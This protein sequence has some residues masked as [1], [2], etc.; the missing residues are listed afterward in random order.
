MA[1]DVQVPLMGMLPSAIAALDACRQDADVAKR[2][3]RFLAGLAETAGNQVT[4]GGH[5][6]ESL[7]SMLFCETWRGTCPYDPYVFP[8][9]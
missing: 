7:F 4:W 5:S 3:L 1:L 6:Q 8:Y 2:G 9:T